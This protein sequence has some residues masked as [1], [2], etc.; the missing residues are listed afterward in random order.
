MCNTLKK[1]SLFPF[2]GHY[3]SAL[4]EIDAAPKFTTGIFAGFG[5]APDHFGIA[6]YARRGG[7][8][9]LGGDVAKAFFV[10]VV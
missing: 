7:V 6:S 3:H 8:I 4:G 10:G 1:P 2:D 5:G 9:A